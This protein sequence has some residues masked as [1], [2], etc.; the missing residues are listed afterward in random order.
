MRETGIMKVGRGGFF[1]VFGYGLSMK[2]P[3]QEPLFSERNGYIVPV[4]RLGGWRVF[5]LKPEGRR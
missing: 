3:E 1:R 4:L 5:V 2:P